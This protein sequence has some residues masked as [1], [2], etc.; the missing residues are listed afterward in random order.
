MKL[1]NEFLFPWGIYC[2][3]QISE[4][5]VEDVSEVGDKNKLEDEIK[6]LKE[7]LK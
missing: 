6:K 3:M 2:L 4:S 1:E 7:E 5:T